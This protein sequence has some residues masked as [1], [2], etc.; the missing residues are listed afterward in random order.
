[1]YTLEFYNYCI[2]Q[3]IETFEIWVKMLPVAKHS[4]NVFTVDKAN[5]TPN[6]KK[7]F[8]EEA[9]LSVSTKAII[10]HLFSKWVRD[11]PHGSV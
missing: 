4:K 2:T 6:F 1:M 5:Y 7:S 3:K 11:T 8:I 10:S 9:T